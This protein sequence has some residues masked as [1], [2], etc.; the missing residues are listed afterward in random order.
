MTWKEKG[1][2]VWRGERQ[3]W[4]QVRS[5]TV[6]GT[7]VL[8]WLRPGSEPAQLTSQ[9]PHISLILPPHPTPVPNP[10]LPSGNEED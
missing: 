1:P 9:S 5:L 8:P 6:L 4:A 3:V 10:I 7:S 2:G